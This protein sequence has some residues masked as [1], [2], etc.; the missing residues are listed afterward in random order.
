M[1]IGLLPFLLNLCLLSPPPAAPADAAPTWAFVEK[2]RVNLGE[3]M[4]KAKKEIKC[5]GDWAETPGKTPKGEAYLVASCHSP[6]QQIMAK[7]DAV[8]AL[9]FRLFDN[10]SAKEARDLAKNAQ[11]DLVKAGCK[12]GQKRGQVVMLTCPNK[13]AAVI[14][15]NWDSKKDSNNISLLFGQADVLPGMLG[16]EAK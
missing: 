2:L 14:L 15:E 13:I 6:E 3:T 16:M 9:G 11:T 8:F 12:P 7:G 4:T 5:D 10:L 1:V